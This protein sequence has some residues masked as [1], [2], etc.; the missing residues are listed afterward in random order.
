MSDRVRIHVLTFGLALCREPSGLPYTWPANHTWVRESEF[1]AVPPSR[2]CFQCAALL[3]KKA[4][5]VSLPEI[6]VPTSNGGR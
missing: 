6:A 3:Q 5:P 2:R 4:R 1:A